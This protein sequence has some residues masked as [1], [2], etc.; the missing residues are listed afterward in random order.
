MAAALAQ[1]GVGAP[2]AA[3]RGLA[4]AARLS[5]QA[6]LVF[7]DR[8]RHGRARRLRAALARRRR[9]RRLP[10]RRAA[11]RRGG[12]GAARE[13][14]AHGVRA[15]D[16]RTARACSATSILRV[17]HLGQVLVTLVT[18]D[19]ALR[20][21]RAIARALMAARPE[22]VGVVQNINRDARQRALRRRGARRW[23][24]RRTSTS[25]SAPCELRLSPTA[26]FQVNRDVAAR[27]YAD[28]ARGG[29]ARPAPSA[30]S[31]STRRRRHRA[32]A[33]AA[34]R[35]EVR[36]H[37][38]ARARG[39]R[40]AAPRRRSTTPRA[41]AS[42]SATSRRELGKL[43]AADVVVLNPP[44]S[45]CAPRGAARGGDARGRGSSST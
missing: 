31:T 14:A 45:G 23:P 29:G 18:A 6:K 2:V 3:V 43:G 11:A 8:R 17:N 20:R 19:D 4:A 36:R 32:D 9:S 25:A 44:R 12:D 37:R 16:E 38:G 15:Y 33:G 34:A 10:R 1:A 42:S 13:L 30:W 28:V 40:R 27:I 7:A 35:A 22:V 21:R 5:Q 39:R 41:R 26:F 24:A